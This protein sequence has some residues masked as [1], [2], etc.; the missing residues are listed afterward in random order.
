[1]VLKVWSGSL[2]HQNVSRRLDWSLSSLFSHEHCRAISQGMW[3]HKAASLIAHHTEHES[4]HEYHLCLLMMVHLGNFIAVKL[5]IWEARLRVCPWECF[6]TGLT[7][8]GKLTLTG[9]LDEEGGKKPRAHM[10]SLPSL[11]LPLP[12]P[13][14][15][16]CHDMSCSTPSCSLCHNERKHWAKW[17]S[18]PLGCFFLVY[19]QGNNNDKAKCL[20]FFSWSCDKWSLRSSLREKG[21]L[22]AHS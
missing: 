21:F 16:G 1:M 5:E 13:S 8:L 18:H 20:H 11:F 6:Q 7:K 17:C 9:E 12:H 14:A 22:L 10:F 19:W 3:C 4:R 15:L 2:T